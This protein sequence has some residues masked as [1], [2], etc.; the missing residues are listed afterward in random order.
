MFLLELILKTSIVLG[1]CGLAAVLLRRGS[2]ASR[3]AVWVAGLAGALAVAIGMI[4]L[5]RWGVTVAAV[6]D[7]VSASEPIAELT[8]IGSGASATPAGQSAATTAA[9]TAGPTPA[10]SAI[11]V[12]LLGAGVL[13]LRLLAGEI[14][15]R[16]L[17]RRSAP[18]MDSR[19]R[20]RLDHLQRTFGISRSVTILFARGECV[21]IT[22]GTRRPVILLPPGAASWPA[23]RLDAVLSHELAHIVRLDVLFSLLSRLAVALCWINPLVWIAARQARKESE[24]ACDD[25][26]LRSGMRASD[27]ADELVALARSLGARRPINAAAPAMFGRSPLE[28]RVSAVLAAGIARGRASLVS[29]GVAALLVVFALPLSA[30]TPIAMT[31]SPPPGQAVPPPP[32]PPKIVPPAPP[33][34]PPPSPAKAMPSQEPPPPTPAA[35]KPV[36]TQPD[37]PPPPPPPPSQRVAPSPAVPVNRPDQPPPPPPP[38]KLEPNFN[39]TWVALDAD[40][41]DSLFAVGLTMIPARFTVTQE[42]DAVTISASHSSGWSATMVYRFDG[43]PTTTEMP[44]RS[45]LELRASMANGR[46]V[47]DSYRGGTWVAQTRYW[48]QGDQLTIEVRSAANTVTTIYRRVE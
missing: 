40:R 17:A 43:T 23:P 11:N 7:V 44:L 41:A 36:R 31:V 27:Y 24:R 32:P 6:V 3:H 16:R 37:A 34:P 42:P 4:A 13:L 30:L 28:T 26:V 35:P 18:A 19:I 48:I 39:G 25:A 45:S 47:V 12:W 22:W 9:V 8:T 1:A 29:A 21:P 5:P 2:A 15:V 46:L 14:G 38:L 20:A 10:L 33:P